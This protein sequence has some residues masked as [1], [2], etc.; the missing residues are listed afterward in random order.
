VLTNRIFSTTIGSS[1][2]DGV[3]VGSEDTVSSVDGIAAVVS[4]RRK[5]N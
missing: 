1:L 3:G 4:S 2:A 5:E